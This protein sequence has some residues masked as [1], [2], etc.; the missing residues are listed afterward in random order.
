MSVARVT[1]RPITMMAAQKIRAKALRSAALMCLNHAMRVRPMVRA[2]GARVIHGADSKA[3]APVILSHVSADQLSENQPHPNHRAIGMGSQAI[4]D[5]ASQRLENHRHPNHRA[6]GK[7]SQAIHDSV[8][9]LMVNHLR[10]NHRASGLDRQATPDL[11][12]LPHPK[13]QAS[14]LVHKMVRALVA[15]CALPVAKTFLRPIWYALSTCLSQSSPAMNSPRF[16]RTS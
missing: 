2:A 4:R 6:T 14:S 3:I 11:A 5:S 16:P 10:P 13:H 8:N 15:P 9:Q 7:G 1:G 12:D